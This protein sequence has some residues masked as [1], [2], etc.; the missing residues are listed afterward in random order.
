MNSY[1]QM[2]YVMCFLMGLN[3][4]FSQVRGQLLLL[5]P[6]PLINKVFSLVS[7]EERQRT[8]SSQ[9]SLINRD[10]V[11]SMAF[12]TRNEQI[13]S[14]SPRTKNNNKPY[15]DYLGGNR[16]QK[17]DKPFCTHCNFSGHTIDRC[18]KLHDY[19]PRYKQKQ[20]AVS[21]N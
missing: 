7:Q 16:F 12:S 19:P 3:D 15:N 18:Y 10:M 4:S 6:I 9:A 17:K 21:V 5:D 8:I 1:F 2:E 13:R 11:N 14:F 20:K